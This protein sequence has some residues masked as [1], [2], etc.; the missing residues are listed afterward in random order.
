MPDRATIEE[1][2]TQ[3]HVAFVGVSRDTK[4]FSNAVYRKLRESGITLYPVN[5]SAGGVPL[6]GD[7]SYSTLA[8]VPDPVDGAFVMVPSSAAA[9]V[10]RDAIDRGIRRVWL[11]RGA[12]QG[13]VSDEA[14]E[15]CR[16]NGARVVDGAC[17]LMFLEPVRGIHRVH[18]L[19]SG[20][21]IAA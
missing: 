21:R 8:D 5:P 3:R 9:A 2:L 4:Q 18:R 7:V 6:E 17:P 12:G 20:R 1:F 13:S 15:I 10:V 19:I 14:V 11:H 16:A